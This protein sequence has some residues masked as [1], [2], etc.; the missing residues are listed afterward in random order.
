MAKLF[1]GRV[2]SQNLIVNVIAAMKSPV[3]RPAQ[4]PTAPA[5]NTKAAMYPIGMAHSQ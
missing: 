2:S 1:P 4:I 5:P 3:A